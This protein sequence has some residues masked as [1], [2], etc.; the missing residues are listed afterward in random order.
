MTQDRLQEI[1]QMIEAWRQ[2]D[3]RYGEAAK[4]A[5]VAKL[6]GEVSGQTPVHLQQRW[7]DATS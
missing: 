7:H 1:Y 3:N 4:T 5:I 2:T 6:L